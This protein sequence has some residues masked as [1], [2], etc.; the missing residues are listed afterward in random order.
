MCGIEWA[1]RMALWREKDATGRFSEV[2]S[3]ALQEG[4]QMIE[5][6]GKEVAVLVS[7]H[8][9]RKLQEKS[10]SLKDVLLAQEPKFEIPIPSRKR[11]R[12]RPIPE[13]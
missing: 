9:W 10:M 7:I 8:E 13:L 6:A 12:S 3:K 11:Y 2:L 1:S 4:P 5:R